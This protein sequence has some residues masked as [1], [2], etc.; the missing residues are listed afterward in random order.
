MPG[1]AHALHLFEPQRRSPD[2]LCAARV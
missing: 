2:R 1:S